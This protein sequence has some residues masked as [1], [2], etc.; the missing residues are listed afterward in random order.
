VSGVTEFTGKRVLITGS[1]SGIGLATARALVES[2]ARVVAVDLAEAPADLSPAAALRGDVGDPAIWATAGDLIRSELGGLDYAFLNAG[3]ASHETDIAAIDDAEFRRVMGV[4]GDG[5]FYGVRTAVREIAAGGGPGAIVATSS[6][7]GLVAFSP[8]PLYTMTKH[9]VVGLVRALAAPLREQR[10][11][12]NAV[13]PGL[14]D[15]PILTA[16]M[17]GSIERE[18]FPMLDAD[19]IVAAVLDLFTGTETGGAWVC[20]PGRPPTR[21]AYRG[22]PG[23][24]GHELP[25]EN[26][27]GL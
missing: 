12:I 16:A 20:Q 3:V 13:C 1:S 9:A 21:Y 17:R 5:V 14:V 24:V 10:V 15:T 27:S 4:N 26:L 18:R 23:P 6:L 7:A 25:P 8:D 11:T 22:V 2:G 19:A